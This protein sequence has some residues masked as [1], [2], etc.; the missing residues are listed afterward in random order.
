MT[1]IRLIPFPMHAALRL[2]TGLVTLAAAFFAGFDVPATIMAVLIGS[3]VVGIALAA[4]PDERGLSPL[5]IDAV[6]VTDWALVLGLMGTAAVVAFD[7]DTRAGAVLVGIGLVQLVG[8]L[9]TRYS[10]RA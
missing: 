1:A 10:L 4:A 3:L 9:T 8:N 6:H 7:G 2:T 5:P